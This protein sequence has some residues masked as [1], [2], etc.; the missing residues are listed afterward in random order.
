MLEGMTSPGV[1]SPGWSVEPRDRGGSPAIDALRR[2]AARAGL[3]ARID[4]RLTAP[5]TMG[6][7]GVAGAVDF[8]LAFAVVHDMPAAGVLSADAA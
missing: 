3:T 7:N 5:Q 2:R 1:S 6:L 4:G 8:M